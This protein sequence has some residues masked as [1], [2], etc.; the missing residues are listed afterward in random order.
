M[1]NILTP[2]SHHLCL[3]WFYNNNNNYYHHKAPT[4]SKKRF[5]YLYLNIVLFYVK[6]LLLAITHLFAFISSFLPHQFRW[7]FFSVFNFFFVL[8]P[9]LSFSTLYNVHVLLQNIYYLHFLCF[10]G[11]REVHNNDESLLIHPAFTRRKKKNKRL[12]FTQRSFI[13][14]KK[15]YEEKKKKIYKF[16]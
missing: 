12:R 4:L 3:L 8:N 16:A 14:E 5:V 1:Q 6:T 13:E 11:V 7:A 2:L 10:L 15:K 9:Y